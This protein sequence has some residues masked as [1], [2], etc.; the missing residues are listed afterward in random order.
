MIFDLTF[1]RQQRCV[2][3]KKKNKTKQNGFRTLDGVNCPTFN[4]I[5]VPVCVSNLN[6][7]VDDDD[8]DEDC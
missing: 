7:N 8:D 3:L 6:L 1:R 2:K 4:I 5:H